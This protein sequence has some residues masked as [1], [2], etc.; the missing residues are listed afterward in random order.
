LHLGGCLEGC[1]FFI[2]EGVHSDVL[3]WHSLVMGLA[4]A[5]TVALTKT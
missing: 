2:G 3:N 1:D 4:F 5:R